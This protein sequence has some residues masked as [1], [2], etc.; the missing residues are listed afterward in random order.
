L[1]GREAEIEALL[2]AFDRVAA[3]GNKELR[4]K[5]KEN[6]EFLVEMMLVSGYSGVGKS[7]LV[8]ELW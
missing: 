1:Y 7:A 3:T 8:Q 6:S 2:A 5:N 4:V